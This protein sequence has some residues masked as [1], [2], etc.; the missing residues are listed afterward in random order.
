MKYAHKS[1]LV[2]APK[3][4]GTARSRPRSR[5]PSYRGGEWCETYVHRCRRFKRRL[6]AELQANPDV[7][8][9][10]IFLVRHAE[11]DRIH[12]LI[13]VSRIDENETILRLYLVD[14]RC[15]L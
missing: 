11:L 4:T 3:L 13:S 5:E 1:D 10:G 2:F 14:N 9:A 12:V 6:P 8:A 7:S 15:F